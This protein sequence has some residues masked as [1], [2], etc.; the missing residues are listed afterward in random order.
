MHL[1]RFVKYESFLQRSL[2]QLFV[3]YS[4][5]QT[6]IIKKFIVFVKFFPLI[7]AWSSERSNERNFLLIPLLNRNSIK[8]LVDLY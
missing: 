7:L 5:L 1:S 6:W 4:H 8:I 2:S 3:T